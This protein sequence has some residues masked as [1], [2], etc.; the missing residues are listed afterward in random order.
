MLGN[1]VAN[2]W[3]T[4]DKTPIAGGVAQ[5][6]TIESG[7]PGVLSVLVMATVDTHIARGNDAANTSKFLLIANTYIEIPVADI[8]AF[9]FWGTAAGNLYVIE[10]LG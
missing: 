10:W 3:L 2:N 8:D 6:Y 7:R 5:N 4:P 1:S 9:S